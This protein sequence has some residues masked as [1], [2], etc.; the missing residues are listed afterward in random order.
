VSGVVVFYTWM[1]GDARIC[2]GRE[3]KVF[4]DS[5]EDCLSLSW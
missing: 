5:I 1:D 4:V 3:S 2:D